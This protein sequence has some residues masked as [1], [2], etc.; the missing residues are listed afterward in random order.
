MC[1]ECRQI[2]GLPA[3]PLISGQYDPI[4]L[5]GNREPFLIFRCRAEDV[6]VGNH[7]KPGRSKGFGSGSLPVATVDEQDRVATRP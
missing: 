7:R 1:D 5:P 4:V 6:I 3:N 2:V